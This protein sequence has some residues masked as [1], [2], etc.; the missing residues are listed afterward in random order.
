MHSLMGIES[1]TLAQVVET[2]HRFLFMW[3]HWTWDLR[4]AVLWHHEAGLDCS[5]RSK[6]GPKCHV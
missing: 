5:L 1:V 6:F 2:L 4:I 3:I